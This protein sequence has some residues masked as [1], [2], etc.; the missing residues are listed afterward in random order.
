MKIV[1]IMAAILMIFIAGCGNNVVVPKPSY[2]FDSA[3]DDLEAVEAKY[4]VVEDK[5]LP[6]NYEGLIFDYEGLLGK[7]ESMDSTKDIQA[8]V[9]V[10]RFKLNLFKSKERMGESSFEVTNDVCERRGE[11]DI[12]YKN[13]M[14]A[15]SFG[16]DS[17][18][19]IDQLIKNYPEQF[20]KTD[21]DE[22]LKIR[23]DLESEINNLESSVEDIKEY[24]ESIC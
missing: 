12:S 6:Q 15:V 14:D 8:G 17:I 7:L 16:R 9:L 3:M 19:A 20:R 18:A 22:N 11:F 13:S 23:E 2:T 5:V 24:I 21:S 1:I 10:V 4:E